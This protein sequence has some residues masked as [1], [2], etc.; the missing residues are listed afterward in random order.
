V[1]P[2]AAFTA[3]VPALIVLGLVLVVCQ[4]RISAW[5]ARRH[6]ATGGMPYHGTR[7]VWPGV[8]VTGVYGGYFGAAQGVILISILAILVVDDLQ[9][10]NGL[11][12]VLVAIVNGVAAVVFMLVAPVSWPVVVLIAI[13][14]VIGGQLG[15]IFGRRLRPNVL[16]AGIVV[17]GMTV[18]IRLL[19]A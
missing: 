6:E 7:W 5:V 14:S 8:L 15:A 3:I 12:N 4:P 13:G 18:A 17:V 10:L 9:R 16:R 19:L 2:A 1:R 11:K